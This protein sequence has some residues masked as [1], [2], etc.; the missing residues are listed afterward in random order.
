MKLKDVVKR[1]FI[2]PRKLTHYALDPEN[3]RGKN[4][5]IMFAQHLGF[6]KD[7]CQRLLDQIEHSVLDADAQL[8][9]LDEYGQRYHID[10]LITGVEGQQETVRTGWIVRPNEDFAR[11]AT[12]YVRRRKK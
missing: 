11:L 5:A 8:G 12:L 6:T 3:E 7:N 2:D 10:L 4:K 9:V 1:V